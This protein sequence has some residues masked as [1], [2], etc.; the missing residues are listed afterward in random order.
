M[1]VFS[2]GIS[3]I[4]LQSYWLTCLEHDPFSTFCL[5][6]P[7][8]TSRQVKKKIIIPKPGSLGIKTQ[9]FPNQID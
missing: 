8:T 5:I 1:C 4:H 6:W 7:N 9:L 2:Y 3:Y